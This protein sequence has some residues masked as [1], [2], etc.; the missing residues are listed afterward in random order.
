MLASCE[1][2]SALRTHRILGIARVKERVEFNLL[3]SDILANKFHF[4][5]R[6][7]F[8]Q[9]IVALDLNPFVWLTPQ[10]GNDDVG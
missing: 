1:S 8:M 6:L 10:F 2:H 9:C 7:V 4:Q 3:L 5:I